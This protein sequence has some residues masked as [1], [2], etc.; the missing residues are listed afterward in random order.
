VGTHYAMTTYYISD[1]NFTLFDPLLF[2]NTTWKGSLNWKDQG[3]SG[4]EILFIVIS[5]I[6]GLLLFGYIIVRR[7]NKNE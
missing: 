6:L 2:E 7:K 4:F 3:R 1:V 5:I